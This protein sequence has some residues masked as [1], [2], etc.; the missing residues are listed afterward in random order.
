M[1]KRLR[2]GQLQ[3]AVDAGDPPQSAD[4]PTDEL[5]HAAQAKWL[6]AW[7]GAPL[8]E[9]KQ[10]RKQWSKRKE[11]HVERV[12]AAAK[13]AERPSRERQPK[14]PAELGLLGQSTRTIAGPP[15]LEKPKPPPLSGDQQT[16]ELEM[17]EYGI[18]RDARR[19]LPRRTTEQNAERMRGARAAIADAQVADFSSYPEQNAAAAAK[20]KT[21]RACIASERERSQRR[22]EAAREAAMGVARESEEMRERRVR[23]EEQEQLLAR[24]ADV[25]PR[26][27]FYVYQWDGSWDEPLL[28]AIQAWAASHDPPNGTQAWEDALMAVAVPAASRRVSGSVPAY[29]YRRVGALHTLRWLLPRLSFKPTPGSLFPDPVWPVERRAE[30]GWCVC[31][32]RLPPCRDLSPQDLELGGPPTGDQGDHGNGAVPFCR[33]HGIRKGPTKIATRYFPSW[34]E[35][36]GTVSGER[37]GSSRLLKI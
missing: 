36:I 1:P 6:A 35:R 24:I 37:S 18:A 33:V 10:R 15:Q 32:C 21:A 16:Y 9:G 13:A 5:W 34:D 27:D 14:P 7:G 8:P 25:L 20:A 23:R 26:A 12:A 3:A 4:H 19:K 11:L 22:R 31:G 17:G 29:A 28:R 2:P 30:E